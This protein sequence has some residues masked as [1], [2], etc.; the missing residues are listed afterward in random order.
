MLPAPVW[1]AVMHHA[2]S[3]K[4]LILAAAIVKRNRLSLDAFQQKTSHYVFIT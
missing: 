1:A 3:K 2:G 4:G